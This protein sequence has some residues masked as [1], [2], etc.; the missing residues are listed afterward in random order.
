MRRKDSAKSEH[1]REK[2]NTGTNDDD[3]LKMLCP[4][5]GG[6]GLEVGGAT[7]VTDYTPFVDWRPVG[8]ENDVFVFG[9]ARCCLGAVDA[10]T[11]PLTGVNCKDGVNGPCKGGVN[12]PACCC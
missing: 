12:G 9:L 6:G 5:A 11:H 7:V 1:Y 10:G 4:T 3:G 8:Q 2:P